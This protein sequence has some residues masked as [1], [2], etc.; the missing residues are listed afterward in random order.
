MNILF[1]SHSSSTYGAENSLSD[2]LEHSLKSKWTPVVICPANGPLIARLRRYG[3]KAYVFPHYPWYSHNRSLLKHCVKAIL[4]RV[5]AAYLGVLHKKHQFSLVYSNTLASFIGSAFASRRRIPHIWHL[6]E[7]LGQNI[8]ATFDMGESA[9]M[10]YL[11]L[12]S[13]KVIFNSETTRAWYAGQIS[14][15]KGIVIPNGLAARYFDAFDRRVLRSG[16]RPFHLSV[17]GKVVPIKKVEVAL[18][19][20]ARLQAD[21]NMKYVLNIVGDGDARYV[22]FLRKEADSLGISASI[23]WHGYQEDPLP[24]YLM[25]DAVLINS[26]LETFSRSACEAMATGCP[27]VVSDVG[28]PRRYIIEGETGCV[29]PV[30]DCASL[31]GQVQKLV[32]DRALVNCIVSRAHEYAKENWAVDTYALRI[33]SVIDEVVGNHASK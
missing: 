32:R 3:I 28:E 26:H 8:P 6:H 5:G 11:K 2:L 1:V 27:V 21:A 10:R 18:N 22:A 19:A 4:H 30:G 17:I 13:D 15:S 14:D 7:F 25:S 31:A 20:L 24:F 12:V 16:N 33:A 9:S 23:E 29:Y